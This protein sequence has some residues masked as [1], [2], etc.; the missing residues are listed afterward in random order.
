MFRDWSG[1]TAV[2]NV[3][4]V[5]PFLSLLFSADC[6]SGRGFA[7]QVQRDKVMRDRILLE[8]RGRLNRVPV[9]ARN[10]VPS[11]PDV[12]TDQQVGIRCSE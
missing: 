3:A 10:A 6:H 2:R 1:H 5:L 11:I 4:R 12:I 8:N 7:S 9:G